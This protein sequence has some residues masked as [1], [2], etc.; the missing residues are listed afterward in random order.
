[1]HCACEKLCRKSKCLYKKNELKVSAVNGEFVKKVG[2]ATITLMVAGKQLQT[3][4]MIL[5]SVHEGVDAV[6]GMDVVNRCGGVQLYNGKIKFGF[7]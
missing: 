3:S 1:M 5:K 4:V 6:I 2:E 7:D